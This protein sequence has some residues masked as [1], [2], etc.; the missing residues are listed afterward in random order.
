V[1]TQFLNGETLWD[2]LKFDDADDADLTSLL[3]T[4][5]LFADAPPSRIYSQALGSQPQAELW[6][7][8]RQ[9]QTQLP[10]YLEQQRLPRASIVVHCQMYMYCRLSSQ[11]MLR[12]PRRTFELTGY[13]NRSSSEASCSSAM[14][15]LCGVHALR[16]VHECMC[17]TVGSYVI[18]PNSRLRRIGSCAS[19]FTQG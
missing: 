6:E 18:G 4:M 17:S 10:A 12:P 15:Y 8:G 13:V 1:H 2:T 19:G 16:S 9:L 3:Q 5:V 7:R 11:S 14:L